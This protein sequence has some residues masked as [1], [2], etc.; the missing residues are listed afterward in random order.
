MSWRTRQRFLPC[1]LSWKADPTGSPCPRRHVLWG[2]SPQRRLLEVRFRCRRQLEAVPQR[3]WR[4][5][6]LFRRPWEAVPQRHLREARLRCRRQREVVPQ[7]HLREARLRRRHRLWEVRPH[8][9]LPQTV[10]LLTGKGRRPGHPPRR[11][12]RAGR[13]YQRFPSLRESR[14]KPWLFPDSHPLRRRKGVLTT[15]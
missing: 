12:L 8:R 15:L 4:R 3:R 2:A 10:G 13:L 11:P 14:R 1:L 9:L 5:A 6:R 7:R